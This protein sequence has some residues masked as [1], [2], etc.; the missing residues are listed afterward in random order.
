M[1]FLLQVQSKQVRQEIRL[2]LASVTASPTL[3]NGNVK[4]L[5]LNSCC[6]ENRNIEG[7]SPSCPVFINSS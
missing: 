2:L 6:Q 1:P 5:K 4:W 7:I 3:L